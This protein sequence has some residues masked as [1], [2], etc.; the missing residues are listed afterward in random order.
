MGTKAV[1]CRDAELFCDPHMNHKGMEG[2][3][4]RSKTLP[5]TKSVRNAYTGLPMPS[6]R[7]VASSPG[8]LWQQAASLPL[9]KMAG[10]R[11]TLYGPALL[12]AAS[13]SHTRT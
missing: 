1:T 6:A 11:V 5:Q 4:A 13:G 7:S 10:T 2:T 9:T 12:C 8:P 3:L